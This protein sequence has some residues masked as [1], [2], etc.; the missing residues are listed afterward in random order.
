MLKYRQDKELRT[1]LNSNVPNQYSFGFFFF[2]NNISPFY[3]SLQFNTELF[4]LEYIIHVS[5][6]GYWHYNN[7]LI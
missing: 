6:N 2:G 5:L 7:A 3:F 4:L 1:T